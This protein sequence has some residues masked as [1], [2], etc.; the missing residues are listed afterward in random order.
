M[1]LFETHEQE[2]MIAHLRHKERVQLQLDSLL[3]SLV[4]VRKE[5]R[6]LKCELDERLE[7]IEIKTNRL[8]TKSFESEC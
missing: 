5:L 1:T 2:K 7:N 6:E 8:E 3:E 4:S